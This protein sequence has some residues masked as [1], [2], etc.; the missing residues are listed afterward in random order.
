MLR[1]TVGNA[2]PNSG[3]LLETLLQNR[4]GLKYM[5]SRQLVA[6]GRQQL[7]MEKTA[8]WTVELEA[9][10]VRMYEQEHGPL[11][12][13]DY[14]TPESN[15]VPSS[16]NSFVKTPPKTT[17]PA[18]K[19]FAT[20]KTPAPVVKKEAR[21]PEP[22]KVVEKEPMPEEKEPVPEEKEEVVAPPIVEDK[23]PEL[24]PEEE[25]EEPAAVEEPMVQVA[26]TEK[27]AE[28]KATPP[29]EE[30]KDDAPATAAD[31]SGD[32]DNEDISESEC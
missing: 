21:E 29:E 14:S 26:T 17:E 6:K 28:P 16:M 10:C 5:E 20:P 7:G 11:Q 32:E 18:K 22:E 13:K 23:T 15:T 12:A 8:P 24:E 30:K 31:S 9:E 2:S 4:L 1:S 19:T 25:E 27:E 3:K